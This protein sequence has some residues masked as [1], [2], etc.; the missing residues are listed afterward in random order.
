MKNLFFAL[1]ATAAAVA[2]AR[3]FQMR[4]SVF[5]ELLFEH[6]VKMLDNVTFDHF[7]LSLVLKRGQY[8]WNSSVDVQFDARD[9]DSIIIHIL[10]GESRYSST[11]SNEQFVQLDTDVVNVIVRCISNYVIN[12]YDDVEVTEK[13]YFTERLEEELGVMFGN[14]IWFAGSLI[15]TIVEI[16]SEGVKVDI[17]KDGDLVES[18]IIQ[19]DKIMGWL[20]Y[21]IA[22]M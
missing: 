11:W 2:T 13:I 20:E 22:R 6:L 5:P 19:W 18:T 4:K 12:I 16:T 8:E 17:E 1:R 7:E 10:D 14:V 3:R 9:S 21:G 15:V